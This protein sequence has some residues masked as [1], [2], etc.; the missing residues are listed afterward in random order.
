M[1]SLAGVKDPWRF[2]LRKSCPNIWE[3]SSM[4]CPHQRACLYVEHLIVSA[5]SNT[6]MLINTCFCHYKK[7]TFVL[8]SSKNLNIL[9]KQAQYIQLTIIFLLV[10]F[11][12]KVI[13]KGNTCFKRI[14]NI[15]MCTYMFMKF[16]KACSMA[17]ITWWNSWNIKHIFLNLPAKILNRDSMPDSGLWGPYFDVKSLIV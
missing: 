5:L 2:S 7:F 14:L 10:V 1:F 16:L 12:K 15:H 3:N 6:K 9:F 11:K 17:I 4:E 8:F 13:L